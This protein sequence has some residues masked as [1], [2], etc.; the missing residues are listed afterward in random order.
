MSSPGPRA[1]ALTDALLGIVAERGLDHVSVREVASAAGVSIGT[2]QH[3][4]PTKDAMLTAAFEE[5]VRR[6]RARILAVQLGPDVR[7]NLSAILREL[8]PL[9]DRRRMEAGIQLAFAARAATAPALAAIQ[10]SVLAEIHTGVAEG[11][12]AAWGARASDARCRRAAQVAVATADGL[13][14]HA[15]SSDGGLSEDDLAAALE[16]VLDALLSPRRG[17]RT[18]GASTGGPPSSRG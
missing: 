6:I 5:V 1:A 8:L 10:R 3:Y 9:D 4:F 15:A 13:A 18:S 2:V 14:L 17:A 12:A 11:F 7:R 16:L